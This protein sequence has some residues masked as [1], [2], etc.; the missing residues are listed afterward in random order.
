MHVHFVQLLVHYV[1]YALPRLR[2]DAMA[3]QGN[4]IFC[5]RVWS[6]SRERERTADSLFRDGDAR[7]DDARNCIKTGDINIFRVAARKCIL[8]E[9]ADRA[10]FFIQKLASRASSLE[11]ARSRRT[12]L[13][14]PFQLNPSDRSAPIDFR[15][16]TTTGE[17]NRQA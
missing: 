5:M 7:R 3:R 10:F 12:L 17:G 8:P 6:R 14:S 16:R 4:R 1:S 2:V 9:I 13:I 11:F 15:D